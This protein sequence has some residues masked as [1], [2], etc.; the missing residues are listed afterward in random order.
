MLAGSPGGK[1]VIKG[2]ST[3]WRKEWRFVVSLDFGSLIK[4]GWL[5]EECLHPGG[6]RAGDYLRAETA[7]RVG[8]GKQSPPTALLH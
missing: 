4:K 8:G 6:A 5:L 3:N 2:S 1:D 7:E